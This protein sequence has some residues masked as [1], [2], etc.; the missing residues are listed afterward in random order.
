MCVCVCMASSLDKLQ[1][2]WARDILGCRHAYNISWSSLRL[3]CGW[4]LRLSSKVVLTAILSLARLQ[5]LTSSHPGHRMLALAMQLP[6]SG[7]VSAV[8]AE[9]RDVSF[10]APITQI[11]HHSYFTSDEIT[12]A[13]SCRETRKL[14]LRR[15]RTQVV[16]PALLE[17]D[18]RSYLDSSSLVA[19]LLGWCRSTLLPEPEAPVVE[20]LDLDVGPLTWRFYRAWALVRI[21]G[22]WPTCLYSALDCAPTLDLCPLCGA[23]DITV[24]HCF[25]HCPYTIGHFHALSV[26]VSSPARTDSST[27]C[28]QVFGHC[29]S[30]SDRAH[31]I[32]FVGKCVHQVLSSGCPVPDELESLLTQLDAAADDV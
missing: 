31:M 5:L 28:L 15:Y 26:D 21:T 30:P 11:I 1:A 27:L 29:S 17:R 32:V 14:V 18:H 6:G 12:A 19:N 8:L 13:Q 16:L 9:M 20:L 4:S 3:L 7:W 10:A 24:V 23:S 2:S 22:A 25:C